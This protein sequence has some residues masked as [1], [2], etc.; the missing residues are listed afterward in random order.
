[1]E[2]VRA[3]VVIVLLMMTVVGAMA[4]AAFLASRNGP[5]PQPVRD[6]RRDDRGS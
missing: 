4:V 6:D 5:E 1:M 3:A 2:I